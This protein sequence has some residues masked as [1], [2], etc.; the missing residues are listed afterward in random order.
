MTSSPTH[1]RAPKSPRNTRCPHAVFPCSTTVPCLQEGFEL[2]VPE[3]TTS[4]T[5]PTQHSGGHGLRTVG[6]VS[7]SGGV[8]M[9]D[10]NR[11]AANNIVPVGTINSDPSTPSQYLSS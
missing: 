8:S 11:I 5:Q 10:V 2:T 4:V 7:L 6:D 9:C 3:G 1:N